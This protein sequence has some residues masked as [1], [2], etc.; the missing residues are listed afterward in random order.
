M[1]LSTKDNI[2]RIIYKT[3]HVVLQKLN[4]RKLFLH[5]L[6]SQREKLAENLITDGLILNLY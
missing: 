4:K 3:L 6:Y 5:P 1:L 2:Q